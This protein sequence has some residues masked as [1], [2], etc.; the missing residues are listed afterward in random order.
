MRAT[1]EVA[2]SI[3]LLSPRLSPWGRRGVGGP[4]CLRPAVDVWLVEHARARLPRWPG[5]RAVESTPS[6]PSPS[7][8]AAQA[9]RDGDLA[10]PRSS[11]CETTSTG[12]QL[13]GPVG[14]AQQPRHVYL[15]QGETAKAIAQYQQAIDLTRAWRASFN[16]SRA[17]AWSGVDTLEKS[18]PSRP[19]P[20][21]GPRGGRC[22]HRRAT[23]GEPQVEQVRDGR[24]L[25]SSQL[26]PLIE[27]QERG[28][29]A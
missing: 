8:L 21:A 13:R 3:S 7:R 6:C 26:E 18:R 23:A 12:L 9:K 19:R 20:A 11:T 15:L 24:A 27:V 29:D 10:T 17:L 28:A 4:R 25:D 22:V 1:A 5:C 14:P 16:V 2:I